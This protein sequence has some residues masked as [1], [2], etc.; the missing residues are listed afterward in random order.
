VPRAVVARVTELYFDEE[1]DRALT[2]LESDAAR[3]ELADRVHAVL[4]ALASDPGQAELRRHRFQV[5][6][7][8]VVVRGSGED[9][10]V[11]WEP[12]PDSDGDVVVQY[13]GPASF[14]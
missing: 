6:V 10:I 3:V 7:W 1:A 2:A 8:G 12:H 13:V 11:L 4:G 14:A 9:W 5:G